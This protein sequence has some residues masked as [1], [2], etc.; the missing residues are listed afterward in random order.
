[1]LKVLGKEFEEEPFF[2]R[3]FLNIT[4]KTSIRVPPLATAFCDKLFN[5]YTLCK[6]SRLI[7]IIALGYRYIVSE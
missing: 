7:H 6:V 2:K 1:M 3:V 4:C 5:S